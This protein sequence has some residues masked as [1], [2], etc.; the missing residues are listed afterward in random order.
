MSEVQ[1]TQF[2]TAQQLLNTIELKVQ[3]RKTLTMNELKAKCPEIKTA[4]VNPALRKKL[5]ISERYV[6]V[7]TEKVIEDIMK[8]GWEPINAYRVKSRGK[9]TGTGRH[10]V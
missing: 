1:D 7:S 8:M 2:S 4:E 9:R 5:G 6:H 3:E 10:M